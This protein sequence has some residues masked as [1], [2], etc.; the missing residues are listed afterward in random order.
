MVAKLGNG[1][2]IAGVQSVPKNIVEGTVFTWGI[3]HWK[4]IHGQG[5]FGEIGAF[6]DLHASARKFLFR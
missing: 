6:Q 4:I 2:S 5:M 1:C 3:G